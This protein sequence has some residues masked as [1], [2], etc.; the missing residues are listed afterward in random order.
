MNVINQSL[1]YTY[2]IL[3]EIC[4]LSTQAND[5]SQSNGDDQ[6]EIKK[7]IFMSRPAWKLHIF[8]RDNHFPLQYYCEE[9]SLTQAMEVQI[10]PLEVDGMNTMM[11]TWWN[12]SGRH[13]Q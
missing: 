1:A 7:I 4:L 11:I 5:K 8:E 6:A 10:L 12:I 9:P 13:K 3:R 2:Y